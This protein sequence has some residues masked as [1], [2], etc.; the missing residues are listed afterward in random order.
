MRSFKI[1]IQGYVSELSRATL[2]QLKYLHEHNKAY[3]Y[4]ETQENNIFSKGQGFEMKDHS[5]KE[6]LEDLNRETFLEAF[7][8]QCIS[9]NNPGAVKELHK[10]YQ[11]SKLIKQQ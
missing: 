9:E 10:F 1:S 3:G 7:H 11:S 2:D 8:K 6:Y 5:Q 4:A